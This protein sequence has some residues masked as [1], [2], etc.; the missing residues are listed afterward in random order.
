MERKNHPYE[1]ENHPSKPPFLGSTI[2]YQGVK[3][4][5]LGEVHFP[6]SFTWDLISSFRSI[7]TKEWQISFCHLEEST[8][9]NLKE[10]TNQPTIHY[11]FHYFVEGHFGKVS[12]R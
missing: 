12:Q 6:Y 4:I 8:N 9:G 10:S 7:V 1:K 3:A 11:L 2:I 5:A